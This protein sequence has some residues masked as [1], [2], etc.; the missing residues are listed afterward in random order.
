M[1]HDSHGREK[2][3]EA[4]FVF[5]PELLVDVRDERSSRAKRRATSWCLL[6]NCATGG[7]LPKNRQRLRS[8]LKGASHRQW[9][10]AV[11][12]RTPQRRDCGRS[13]IAFCPHGCR[14]TSR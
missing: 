1:T 6:K 5:V 2:T 13:A 12:T 3:H 14:R 10:A 4:G 9:S 7:T 11:P 8:D